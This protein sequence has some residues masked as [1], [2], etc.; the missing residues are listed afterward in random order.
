MD[1]NRR[2]ASQRVKTPEAQASSA[3]PRTVK[4]L[5]ALAVQIGREEAG[6]SP[7]GKS[8]TVLAKLVEQPDE[9]AVRSITELAASLGVNASTLSRLVRRLGYEGFGDFQKVFRDSLTEKH[10]HFY[11]Q[12]AERLVASAPLRAEGASAEVAAM[13]RL[14]HES[15]ANVEGFLAQLSAAELRDAAGLLARAPRVRFYGLRQFSAL[16]SFMAYGLGLIRTDV[17]LLDA[18]GLGAAEG[19]AQL[20]RG[21]VLVVASVSPYTRA[22]AQVAAAAHKAGIAVVAITDTRASPLAAPARHAFFVPHKSS[23]FSNSMG[24]YL[25]FA[26]GLLNVVATQIGKKALASLENSERFIEALKV[27][28][29]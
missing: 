21:D 13:A 17:G 19:L 8:H 14:A 12:Q 22:V 1:T 16:A 26:E 27:E 7:H 24:A 11:S 20:Q 18:H 2:P 28:V 4:E 9:V 25:I 23:F 15:V 3:A 29:G 10:R 5:Q 6:L